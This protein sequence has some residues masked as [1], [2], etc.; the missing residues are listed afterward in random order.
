MCNCILKSVPGSLRKLVTG[1]GVRGSRRG[2]PRAKAPTDVAVARKAFAEIQHAKRLKGQ[3]AT[4]LPRHGTGTYGAFALIAK[5]AAVEAV[6][7]P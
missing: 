5:V 3:V 6:S 4:P 2:L 7:G 1:W